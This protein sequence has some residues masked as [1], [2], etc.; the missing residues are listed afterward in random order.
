[1][2]IEQINNRAKL[3]DIDNELLFRIIDAIPLRDVLERII[4]ARY[5]YN[6][7][8]KH[9]ALIRA[10]D[11]NYSNVV[12]KIALQSPDHDLV[13]TAISQCSDDELLANIARGANQQ[14]PTAKQGAISKLALQR[15]ENEEVFLHT[16]LQIM[17]KI[18]LMSIFQKIQKRSSLR[19]IS[20]FY[21]RLIPVIY[22][23]LGTNDVVTEFKNTHKYNLDLIQKMENLEMETLE[24]KTSNRILS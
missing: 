5:K 14:V 7:L 10:I 23:K 11:L 17:D 24:P 2:R 22:T 21:I 18:S 16:A 3:S 20:V 8:I 12:E 6:I 9:E 4:F 1:M 19:G 15:I 13:K